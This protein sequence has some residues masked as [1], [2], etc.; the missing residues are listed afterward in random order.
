M[1]DVSMVC[2][3]VGKI[4]LKYPIGLLFPTVLSFKHEVKQFTRN[5][6]CI[7]KHFT[8]HVNSPPILHTV[9][10]FK[11]L[12]W[13]RFPTYD[14]S[15]LRSVYL[16]KFIKN[17]SCVYEGLCQHFLIVWLFKSYILC[18]S[19]IQNEVSQHHKQLNIYFYNLK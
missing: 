5:Y 7:Y 8:M 10:Y 1:H 9:S 13:Q 3:L 15:V 16:I 14:V 18:I 2:Y 4:Y 12:C 17:V 19:C 6:V 11:G